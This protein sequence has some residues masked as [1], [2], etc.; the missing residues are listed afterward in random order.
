MASSFDGA[1]SVL[2]G[3]AANKSIAESRNIKINDLVPLDDY[4]DAR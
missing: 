4:R 1:L 3:A 2:I